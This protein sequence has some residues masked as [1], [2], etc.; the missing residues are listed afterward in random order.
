MLCPFLAMYKY[1]LYDS[2]GSIGESMIAESLTD[3]VAKMWKHRH[4]DIR[5]LHSFHFFGVIGFYQE[6][7]CK[8]VFGV[9]WTKVD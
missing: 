3:Y 4:E 8:N 6:S 7:I 2:F 9:K 5:V 1:Q